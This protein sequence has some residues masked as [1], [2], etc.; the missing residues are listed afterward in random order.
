MPKIE[1]ELSHYRQLVRELQILLDIGTLL[2]LDELLEIS[3][4][5]TISKIS[6][7]VFCEPEPE[8]EPQSDNYYED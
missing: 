2:T 7:L 5:I 3:P 1:I 8:P 4:A 6:K